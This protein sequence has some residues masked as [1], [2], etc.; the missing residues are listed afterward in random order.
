[1]KKEKILAIIPARSGSRQVH[2]KNIKLLNSKPLIYYTI[3]E[4]LD[5]KYIN[6]V[7]LSTDDKEIAEIAKSYGAEIPFIRP[8][9]ISQFTS[10]SLSVILYT[11]DFLKKNENYK[12]DI[13]VFLQP[14]SPLRNAQQIDEAIK[15]VLEDTSLDGV[16]GATNPVHHPF[17]MFERIENGLMI[18]YLKIKNRPVRRQELPEL[19]VTNASLYVTRAKYYETAKDPMPICPIFEGKVKAIIMDKSSSKDIDEE[20]DFLICESMMKNGKN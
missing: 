14:T 4:A 18:P 9:E 17:M 6:R 8:K 3:K 13:V 11:L 12:P 19:F 16:F 2:R 5:S 15:L 20:I 10:S 7:T 1:M